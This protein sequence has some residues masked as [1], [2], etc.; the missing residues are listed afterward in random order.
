MD[1]TLPHRP[2]P[3]D[4]MTLSLDGRTAHAEDGLVPVPAKPT[5]AMLAAGARSAGVSVEVAWR[6][7]RAMVLHED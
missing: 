4:T 3:G 7:Y 5:A 1:N 6:I 2:G